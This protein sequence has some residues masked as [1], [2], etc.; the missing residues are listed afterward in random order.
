VKSSGYNA[1]FGG[2]TGGVISAISKSGSNAMHGSGGMY[3]DSNSLRGAMRP[4]WRINP[5]TDAGGNFPG[6]KEEV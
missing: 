2:A 4:Y 1:E 6:V 3:Y 5:F